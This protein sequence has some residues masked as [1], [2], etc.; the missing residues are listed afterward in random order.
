MHLLYI[1]YG[2]YIK[3]TYLVDSPQILFLLEVVENPGE[4]RKYEKLN[5]KPVLNKSD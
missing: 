5:L 2:D 1:S 4:M 3:P